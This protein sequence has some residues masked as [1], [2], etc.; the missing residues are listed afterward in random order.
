MV[1]IKDGNC[2]LFENWRENSSYKLSL[3]NNFATF[4]ADGGT[5]E[6]RTKTNF[7]RGFC[8]DDNSFPMCRCLTAK[9]KVNFFELILEEIA[10]YCPEISRNKIVRNSGLCVAYYLP[11]LRIPGNWCTF[12]GPCQY[13]LGASQTPRRP[14]S[15][16]NGMHL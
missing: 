11:T 1:T 15:E 2:R 14:L 7:I 16:I 9:Q 12:S 4:L 3:D 13:S 5:W 8:D 6:K 10:N